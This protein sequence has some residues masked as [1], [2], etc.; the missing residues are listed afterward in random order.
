M[1]FI[2]SENGSLF[3]IDPSVAKF[4]GV[5]LEPAHN[6]ADPFPH[7]VIDEFLPSS[8]IK[9]CQ[10]QFPD[11]PDPESTTFHR[12]QERAKTQFSPDYLNDELRLIFATLS[13]RPFI[14]ILENITGIS[15]L[16]AD[17][18]F[19]GGGF[20][21]TQT[22]GHLGVHVDFNCHK[23]LGL[24]RRVNLIIYLNEDWQEGYGGQ[25]ELWDRSMTRCVQ[26]IVPIANRAVV[27][28]TSDISYHGHVNP[29][30]EP[31]G[32]SRRSIALYFY[33]ATWDP[34]KRSATTIFKT[35]PNS[36]DVRDWRL[37][38][39]RFWQ[40]FTPPALYRPALRVTRKLRRFA[41]Q[42]RPGFPIG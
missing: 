39:E 20:H 32:R 24:E 23:K 8:I 33:T 37:Q 7:T 10:E 19:M 12:R 41:A 17:P 13:G 29:V 11:C 1:A 14:H 3:R 30:A 16:I 31:T 18:Y 5:E 9:I 34:T 26:S 2:Q 35:R 22:G 4:T 15:G 6:A 38:T 27:F 25:L 36:G 42:Q 21:E 28:S 40:E